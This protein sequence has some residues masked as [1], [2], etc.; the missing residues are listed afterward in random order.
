MEIPFYGPKR[1]Y[2]RLK[3]ELSFEIDNLLNSNRLEPELEDY[4]KS[5]ENDFTKYSDCKYA[6]GTDSGTAALQLSMLALGIGKGDEVITTSNTYIA[7]ALAISNV[8]AKPVF[9]DV[10]N[11]TFNMNPDL[12]ESKITGRT[13]AIMPVHLYGQPCNMRKIL[14]FSKE[15]GLKVVN[16]ACQAHGSEYD[17]KKVGSLGDAGCFSFY[18]SKNLAGFGNGG[19]VISNDKHLIEKIRLLRNPESNHECVLL[20]KRTP[21]FLD[22]IQ[23]AVLKVKLKYLDKWNMM[24][25]EIAKVYKSLL[26]DTD[27]VI[28][29]EKY[30]KHVFQNFVVKVKKRDQLQQFLKKNCVETRV[31][32]TPPI[33]LSKTFQHLGY[34]SGSLPVTEKLDQEI[35]ALPI[36]PYLKY[37]EI[38]KVADKIKLFY[39]G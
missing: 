10:E 25:R 7:T 27:V 31:E 9:V 3:N 6:V 35:L 12:L 15:H 32:Y 38:K 16:D 33:H 14:R 18:S 30:G 28:P 19:M 21:A 11:D 8:G 23:V 20:T 34:K 22:S 4:L 39:R 17:G 24:R 37:H 26:E 1:T 13:K 36:Y 29:E 2:I 5:F